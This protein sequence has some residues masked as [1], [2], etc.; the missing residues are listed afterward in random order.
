MESA[1]AG[2]GHEAVTAN[3]F[4]TGVRAGARSAARMRAAQP[5]KPPRPM[6]GSDAHAA[7]LLVQFKDHMIWN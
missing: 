3:G 2:T 7:D 5:Q 1:P 4:L 6:S